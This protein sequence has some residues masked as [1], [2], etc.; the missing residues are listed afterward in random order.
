M[1]EQL[2]QGTASDA[3]SE[4][5]SPEEAEAD[6]DTRREEE[7]LEEESESPI[8]DQEVESLSSRDGAAAPPSESKN[9]G[10]ERGQAQRTSSRTRNR[11]NYLG[12]YKFY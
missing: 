9:P 2:A 10:S 4:P 11:P 8:V 5:G 7:E 12:S 3:T 6:G 1:V